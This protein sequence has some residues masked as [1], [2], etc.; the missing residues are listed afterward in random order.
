MTKTG[1]S[2]YGVPAHGRHTAK[3]S[4]PAHPRES[5]AKR[6]RGKRQRPRSGYRRCQSRRSRKPCGP[7]RA[8]VSVDG[9]G[10]PVP[11]S[12]R[13]RRAKPAGSMRW[14]GQPRA[15]GTNRSRSDRATCGTCRARS[16][17]PTLL[18]AVFGARR[19]GCRRRGTGRAPPACRS[20]RGTGSPSLCRWAQSP[21]RSPCSAAR[22]PRRGCRTSP[23]R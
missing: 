7:R 23:R 8:A 14:Y 21:S 5:A 15:C 9:E 17:R 11:S 2:A 16:D 20:A 19:A 4:I 1:R 22:A 13:R 12:R 3:I 6:G 18:R 10:L